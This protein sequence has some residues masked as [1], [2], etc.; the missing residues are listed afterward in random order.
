MTRASQ[1]RWILRSI[2]VLTLAV[3]L[4]QRLRPHP[5]ACGILVSV[6]PASCDIPEEWG[7]DRLVTLNFGP[8][9]R[10]RINQDSVGRDAFPVQLTDIFRIRAQKIVLANLPANMEVGEA[11][12]YLE[13]I[14][15]A[16]PGVKIY[17]VTHKALQADCGPPSVLAPNFPRP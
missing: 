15:D 7:D 12:S 6:A 13:L 16:V 5:A 10:P 14:R 2:L 8:D 4:V 17:L 3:L 11:I 9:G 1:F